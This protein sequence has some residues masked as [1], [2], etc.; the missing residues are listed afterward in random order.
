MS[1]NPELFDRATLYRSI[2]ISENSAD[3]L[4]S[5]GIARDLNPL[6]E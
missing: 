3:K 5:S 6:T 2:L 1:K 4:Q